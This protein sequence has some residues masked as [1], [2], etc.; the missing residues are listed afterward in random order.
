MLVLFLFL[1]N[2]CFVSLIS[3]T[4]FSLN[5]NLSTGNVSICLLTLSRCKEEKT[6]IHFMHLYRTAFPHYTHTN[7]HLYTT[8]TDLQNDG[9]TLSESLLVKKEKKKKREGGYLLY[10]LTKEDSHCKQEWLH[11]PV[12]FHPSPSGTLPLSHR[13]Q[14]NRPPGYTTLVKY[15]G[16]TTGLAGKHN[17]RRRRIRTSDRKREGGIW[18]E[19]KAIR[20]K[21]CQTLNSCTQERW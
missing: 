5:Q 12:S 1:Y 14:N 11:S 10:S 21:K 7:W 9:D 17:N 19:C 2:S 8:C 6:D 18:C 20:N 3:N 13:G 15:L 4:L 16:T